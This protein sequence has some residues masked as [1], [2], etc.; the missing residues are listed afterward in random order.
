M[1]K[2]LLLTMA[3]G[4]GLAACGHNGPVNP[5]GTSTPSP[6]PT[7]ATTTTPAAWPSQPVTRNRSVPVPP[8]PQLT[9]IRS[10]AHPDE[11]YDRVVFDFGSALPGYDIRYVDSVTAAGSG[12]PVSVAGHS[13]LKITF[14]PAQAH[15]ESGG[16]VTRSMTLGLPMVK[17]YVIT[18][19]FEGVLTV[20]LGLERT[21]GF[22]VI[23]L[24][25]TPARVAVDV[26]A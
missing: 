1:K 22:R 14:R 21:V 13:Y 16:Q 24:P 9:G 5:P 19:D 6:P 10:A 17:A 2:F 20:V 25:G 23:E 15:D 26:A 8:V 3:L 18:D 7:T 11:G 4:L 12:T